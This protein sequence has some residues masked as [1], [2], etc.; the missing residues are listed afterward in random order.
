MLISLAVWWLHELSTIGNPNLK[1][2]NQKSL[3]KQESTL[4]TLILK[5]LK[6]KYKSHIIAR[7]N[8]INNTNIFRLDRIFKISL[9]YVWV[10]NSVCYFVYKQK[11]K[12]NPLKKKVKSNIQYQYTCSQ[13]LQYTALKKNSY[14]ETFF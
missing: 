13:D 7:A 1:D 6:V 14:I 5:K 12:S 9:L 2:E 11:V 10:S 4:Y 8:S 3:T